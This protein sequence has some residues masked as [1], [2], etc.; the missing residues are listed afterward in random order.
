MTRH[1]S[2]ILWFRQDL[3]LHHNPALNA[4]LLNSKKILPIYIHAPEEQAPWSPGAASRWWLYHSLESLDKALQKKGSRLIIL[5]GNSFSILQQIIKETK[6]T[7]VYW[8]RLYEPTLME[9]DAN[10][11]KNLREQGISVESYNASLLNEPWEVKNQQGQPYRVFT[12]YWRAAQNLFSV[13]APTPLPEQF[14]PGADYPAL[15]LKELDL[16][17]H[18]NWDSEF[19]N[20]WSPGEHGALE[21]LHGFIETALTKYKIDRDR[22]DFSGTS[23]LSPYLHFGEISPQQIIWQLKNYLP[24]CANSEH[25]NVGVDFYIRE[26]GWREFSHQLLFHFPQ[27]I[28]QPLNPAFRHFPWAEENT[29][30]LEAWRYGRTGIPIIDAGMRELWRTGWM[31]NRVRMIVASFLTKNLRHHWLHGA[32]WFWNTLVDADL[33]N[34]TQGWQWVAGSGADA[35]PYFRIFNPVTQGERFDPE[36]NYVRRWVSELAEIPIKLIHQPWRDPALLRRCGYPLPI[37]DLASSRQ[38]ALAAYREMQRN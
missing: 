1:D 7:S 3:R 5:Q 6:A 17:P 14:P 28:E 16:L 10:I 35:A 18:I 27:T 13:A 38:A 25:T 2:G 33:A 22:P 30:Q 11:K 31:H 24:A 15:A 34:N 29:E 9:R 4:A 23:R 26:L 19:Y 12:P 21:A 20:Y 36:G 37:V 8:N 32:R